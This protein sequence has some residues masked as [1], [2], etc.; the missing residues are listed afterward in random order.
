MNR[1]YKIY[2]LKAQEE[3]QGWN[4]GETL[5]LTFCSIAEEE[6]LAKERGIG[7]GWKNYEDILM[8]WVRWVFQ[9]MMM[10][11]TSLI[12]S[13]R[14]VLVECCVRKP[15]RKGLRDEGLINN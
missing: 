10:E 9:K 12:T 4:L 13:D 1:K 2:M 7:K 6:D 5:L 11:Y 3:S 8:L 14:V 15:H